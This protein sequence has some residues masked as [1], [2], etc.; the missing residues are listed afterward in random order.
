MLRK[1]SVNHDYLG[2]A[3]KYAHLTQRHIPRTISFLGDIL[4][5]CLTSQKQ[6]FVLFQ[7]KHQDPSLNVNLLTLLLTYYLLG[8]FV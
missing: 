1:I 8:F 5:P 6:Q 2:Q 4:N 7:F 3:K